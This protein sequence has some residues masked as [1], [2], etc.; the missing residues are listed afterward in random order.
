ME[1]LGSASQCLLQRVCVWVCWCVYQCVCTCVYMPVYLLECLCA[2]LLCLGSG[3]VTALQ[4]AR[5]KT[6]PPLPAHPHCFGGSF[7]SFLFSVQFGPGEK[8]WNTEFRVGV[9]VE[10]ANNVFLAS[11]TERRWEKAILAGSNM[12]IQKWYSWLADLMW[13]PP[14]DPS[15]CHPQELLIWAIFLSHEGVNRALGTIRKFFHPHNLTFISHCC[16]KSG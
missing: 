12:T 7:N 1:D 11:F 10:S 4:G 13:M 3:T 14:L 9:F 5:R 15:P 8:V 6:C 2:L 16:Q